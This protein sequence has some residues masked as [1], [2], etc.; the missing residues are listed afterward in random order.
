MTG[1]RRLTDVHLLRMRESHTTYMKN[2]AWNSN[3]TPQ[4]IKRPS[5]YA[6]PLTFWYPSLPFPC[7]CRTLRTSSLTRSF[8][9]KED[10]RDPRD[11]ESGSVV[12]TSQKSAVAQLMDEKQPDIL[13]NNACVLLLYVPFFCFKTYRKHILLPKPSRNLT[14]HQPRTITL[15]AALHECARRFNTKSTHPSYDKKCNFI[16]EGSGWHNLTQQAYR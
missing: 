3:Q 10:P 12:G 9:R 2:R 16:G 11:E 8:L 6:R 7:A 14:Q 1:K 13:H 4:K 5:S 15:R